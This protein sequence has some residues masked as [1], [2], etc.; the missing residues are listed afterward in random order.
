[1][2]ATAR[3][4]RT[5]LARS[6]A[7]SAAAVPR[8]TVLT[9]RGFSSAH[10]GVAQALRKAGITLRTA[11]SWERLL[12]IPDDE[13]FDAVLID[14]DAAERDAQGK[15][16][17]ISGHRLVALLARQVAA[18]PTALVVMTHLDY[19]EVEELARGVHVLLHPDTT[20]H[21]CAEHIRARVE[22]LGTARSRRAPLRLDDREIAFQPP[23][24]PGVETAH[25]LVN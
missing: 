24:S 18:K 6:R 14:L 4:P 3:M 10:K 23:A 20:P 13:L 15:R 1:M 9:A 12:L 8:L 19:A 11:P 17:A 5:T 7:S 25:V 21:D 22:R 16:Q 2:A